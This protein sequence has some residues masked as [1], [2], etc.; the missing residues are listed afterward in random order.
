MGSAIQ[1]S[2]ILGFL[3]TDRA[4][5]HVMAGFSDGDEARQ[6]FERNLACAN[7]QTNRTV[8]IEP[9]NRHDAPGYF[10][11]TTDQALA[12]IK[13]VDAPNL[14]LVFDCYHVGRT[15]G[16]VMTGLTDLLTVIGHIQFASV[17]DRGAPD[18][19]E[20]NYK[21][22]FAHI[23]SLQWDVPVGA[24]FIPGSE[25]VFSWRKLLTPAG[26]TNF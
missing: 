1:F 22:I 24:E 8:L 15:E 9:L 23:A 19:G 3:W 25:Q 16:H 6:T 18:H 20:L 21:A 14:R 4:A 11:G 12:I 13:R 17:P 7:S 2:A 26:K 5:I 10:L